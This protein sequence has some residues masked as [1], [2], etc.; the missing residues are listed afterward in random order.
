[1]KEI[2]YHPL[3]W[4]LLVG[5]P[6]LMFALSS[7]YGGIYMFLH[8][9]QYASLGT[10]ISNAIPY[11]LLIYYIILLI[12]I[13]YAMKKSH[14][15]FSFLG[16]VRS[17]QKI[18]YKKELLFGLILGSILVI[19]TQLLSRYV[20]FPERSG[21]LFSPGES[22]PVIMYGFVTVFVSPVVEELLYRGYAFTVLRTKFGLNIA[23]F[24]SAFF[25]S[26][27]HFGQGLPGLFA[28]FVVGIVFTITFWMRKNLWHVIV[29]HAIFNLLAIVIF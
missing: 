9:N 13:L 19:V 28:G 12:L 20:L 17:E 26:L 4:I 29:A 23:I 25:F 7:L 21:G 24:L 22:F 10:I 6:I 27:S 8:P 14:V 2:K 1:M 3:V 15:T 5:A 18:E 16:L 11:I